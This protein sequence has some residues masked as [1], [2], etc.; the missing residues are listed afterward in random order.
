MIKY[1]FLVFFVGVAL[2]ASA[3]QRDGNRWVDNNLAFSIVEDKIK[4]E[5]VFTF[6]ILDTSR[7]RCI[8][9]LSTGVEVKVYDSNDKMLWEGLASGKV[10]QL[11]LP[12]ALPGAKYML[13]KAFKPWVANRLTGTL[14]H[15]E[16]PIE[17][18]YYI[19]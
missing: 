11:K 15:Q 18:K 7:E 14:I 4:K 5:G 2:F 17:L 3:Q 13:I 6:C 12:R 9:N 10:K 19:K 16:K 1:R 8:E